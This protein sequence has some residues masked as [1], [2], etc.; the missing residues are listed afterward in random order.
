MNEY[1]NGDIHVGVGHGVEGVT[2]YGKDV[3]TGQPVALLRIE[4]DF[5]RRIAQMLTLSS[6]ACEELREKI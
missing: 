1:G 6:W 5:A 3:D 2:L 4:P